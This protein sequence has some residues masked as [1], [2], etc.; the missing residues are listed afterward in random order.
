MRRGVEPW[1]AVV[2]LRDELRELRLRLQQPPQGAQEAGAHQLGGGRGRSLAAGAGGVQGGGEGRGVGAVVAAAAARPRAPRRLG[3]PS[4][5]RVHVHGLQH[6]LAIRA[7]DARETPQA[8]QGC[9]RLRGGFVG[10]VE[11]VPCLFNGLRDERADEARAH[12]AVVRG[13]HTGK[14]GC[15]EVAAFDG[16]RGAP[17]QAVSEVRGGILAVYLLVLW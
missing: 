11:G 5:Q 12:I 14:H 16:E 6:L 15:P 9:D 13:G 3:E 17:A 4:K 7:T 1:G 10:R 2:A 8:R